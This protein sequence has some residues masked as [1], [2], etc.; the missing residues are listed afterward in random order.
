MKVISTSKSKLKGVSKVDRLELLSTSDIITIHVPK[1]AGEIMSSS[2]FNALKPDVTLINTSGKEKYNIDGLQKFLLTHC[3][4]AYLFL[5]LPE[6]DHL[7]VLRGVPN[8]ILYPLFTCF[9][10]EGED[11]RKATTIENLLQYLNGAELQ[12][13]V[14]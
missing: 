13:R 3:D 14:L 2:D 12:T 9:T 11:K 8:A 4:S 5:A 7:D 10:K 6:S 1:S